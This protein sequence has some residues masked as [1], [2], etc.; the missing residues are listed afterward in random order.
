[1][2]THP[3]HDVCGGQLV[4][5]DHARTV[6]VDMAFWWIILAGALLSGLRT[7]AVRDRRKQPRSPNPG[8]NE[9]FY[10]AEIYSEIIHYVPG[11]GLRTL[12]LPGS[13]RDV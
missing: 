12:F 3:G 6:D 8:H 9:L 13:A 5:V 4:P 10:S 2:R 11:F 7:A 1:M